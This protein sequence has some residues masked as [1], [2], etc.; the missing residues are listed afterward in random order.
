MSCRRGQYPC[1]QLPSFRITHYKP[2]K[3]GNVKE[4]RP[5][6]LGENILRNE[7]IT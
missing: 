1:P 6:L 7:Y 2:K 5:A 4:N 3:G